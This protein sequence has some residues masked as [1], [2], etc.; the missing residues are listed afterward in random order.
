MRLFGDPSERAHLSCNL[1][2]VIHDSRGTDA[3]QKEIR[4]ILKENPEFPAVYGLA[5][6][7]IEAW[8]LGDIENV[9]REVFRIKPFPKL[10]RSPER[11]PDPKTTLTEMFVKPSKHVNF[12]RW[13]PDCARAVAPFPRS[14]QVSSP[15]P[16]GFG[17][18]IESLRKNR[19]LK[20][21]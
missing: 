4:T 11:D 10:E 2:V 21:R 6:Q 17:K 3:I 15:C 19:V 7:E 9:N 14:S 20:A 1:F 18:F 12:D 5:I 8:V 16:K 13:N